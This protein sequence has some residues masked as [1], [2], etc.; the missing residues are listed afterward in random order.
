MSS[1]G[2]RSDSFSVNLTIEDAQVETDSNG[3]SAINQINSLAEPGERGSVPR[4][5]SFMMELVE[6]KGPPQIFILIILIAMAFGST[7][8]VVPAV[9][10]D[11]YA[12]LN[13]GYSDPRDCGSYVSIDDKPEECLLG[14]AEAQDATAYASLVSNCLTF[15]MASLLGAISDEV[16]RRDILILGLFLSFTSPICLVLIQMRPSMSPNWYYIANASSGLVSWMSIILS[17]LSDV[18]PPKWRAAGFGLLLASFSVGLALS[19]IFAVFFNHFEVSVVSLCMLMLAL[20]VIVF[21]FPETLPPSVAEEAKR[22][23]TLQLQENTTSS[24]LGSTLHMLNRPVRELSILN[25]NSFF[26]LLAS[27]AFFSGMVSQAD[28]S[29]LLYYLEDR[30]AFNDKDIVKMFIL[31]GVLGILVQGILIKPFIQCLGE[32]LVIVMAFLIGSIVNVLYG[33]ASEK[34]MIFVALSLGSFVGM[35]F[36]TIS[37]IKANNVKENEQGRI[38]GAL[39]SVQA[40]AAGLGPMSL[41]LVFHFTKDTVF[42]GPGAMWLFAALLFLIATGFALILPSDKANSTQPLYASGQDGYDEVNEE[43]NPTGEALLQ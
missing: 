30:L 14:S 31:I 17:S 29:L 2:E 35:S 27:L 6:K 24:W 37:A 16:G 19:P 8:G 22:I 34:W 3:Y 15:I 23:R 11:R 39:F 41:R 20:S 5:K 25:R 28:Q 1:Q 10:T 32:K 36:P 7:V 26:R 38:Q 42:P 13:H 21:F 9:M 4:Q 12:R 43:Q 33:I 40:L 18:L